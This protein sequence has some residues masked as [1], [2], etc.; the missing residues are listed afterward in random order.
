MRG[1]VRYGL[2]AETCSALNRST[3][4]S[5]Q[6]AQIERACNKGLR[7]VTITD[8]EVSRLVALSD[9]SAIFRLRAAQLLGGRIVIRGVIHRTSAFFV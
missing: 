4:L 5:A 8:R 9:Q 1:A 7:L 2:N 6:I 3:T